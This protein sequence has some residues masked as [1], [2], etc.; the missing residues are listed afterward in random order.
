MS[1]EKLEEDCYLHCEIA[2]KAESRLSQIIAETSVM[3]KLLADV[4]KIAGSNASVFI[5]GESG[6]GKEV[7]AHAI[8]FLS[9]RSRNPFIKVNCAAIPDTLIESEFFGHEKGAF[10]GAVA[11]RKGRFELANT[12]TLL[13]DEV[14]EIPMQLQS[15][16]LRVVQEQEFERVGGSIPIKVNVRLIST[17]N[18]D[19]SQ[20]IK[21]NRFR[22]DLFY[23]LN[24]VPLSLPPLRKRK[25]DIIPLATYFLQRLCLENGKEVKDLTSNA[26]KKLLSYTWP[27]NIR[28]LGN[29]IER[30]VILV[31][32]EKIDADD[33]IFNSSPANR[34]LPSGISLEEL[35]KQLIMQ[36]LSEHQGNRTQTAKT[37]GIS[38]RTLRN[39]LA[40]LL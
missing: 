36:T 8:H 31:S 35:E 6:T 7:L 9:K 34:D 28:E 16:L 14:T 26:M 2:K 29:V 30:A 15:K 19:L 23:R 10:T 11:Q 21:E 18:R 25:E 38:Q 37:L 33:L 32:G 22:E 12:G 13:L 20:A 3:K 4:K 1:L 24:V 39:K 27:G 5:Y 40:K 17:S